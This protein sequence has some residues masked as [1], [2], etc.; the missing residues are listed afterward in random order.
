MQNNIGNDTFPDYLH[1]YNPY[2]VLL[3][4]NIHLFTH[5]DIQYTYIN[6]ED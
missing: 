2:S 1:L 5:K 3:Y 4:Y 6:S